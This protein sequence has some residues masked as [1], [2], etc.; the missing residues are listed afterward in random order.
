LNKV[1]S[2][3]ISPNEIIEINDKI[4]SQ[5]EELIEMNFRIDNIEKLI[6]ELS[7]L[8]KDRLDKLD[9]EPNKKI[10][11]KSTP[12]NELSINDKYKNKNN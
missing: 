7:D 8:T 3:N 9:L 12:K 6:N 2:S 5:D 1:K 10:Q 11:E 4:K